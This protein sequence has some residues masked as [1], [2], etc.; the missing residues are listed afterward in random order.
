M[1]TLNAKGQRPTM[2]GFK[3]AHADLGQ[4]IRLQQAET[5]AL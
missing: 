2:R 4:R 3:I 5:H 1:I